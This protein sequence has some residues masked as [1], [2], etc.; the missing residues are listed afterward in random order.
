MNLNYLNNQIVCELSHFRH[1]RQKHAV[2]NNTS[3]TNSIPTDYPLTLDKNGSKDDTQ[4]DVLIGR[5]KSTPASVMYR[6]IAT[7]WAM[8]SLILS[9]LTIIAFLHPDWVVT[10]TSDGD[11]PKG[12]TSRNA[13]FG[14]YRVCIHYFLTKEP[15]PNFLRM[16][17][18][19]NTEPI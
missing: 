6:P 19:L 5:S 1:L 3:K 16:K 4:S 2:K 14:V 11:L 10:R 9:F 17:P 13:K 8:F 12:T 15:N 7:A 18:L